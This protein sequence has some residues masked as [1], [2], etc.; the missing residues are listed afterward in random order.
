MSRPS[1]AGRYWPAHSF[2]HE[3]DAL[4]KLIVVFSL[5]FPV[6]LARDPTSILLPGLVVALLWVTALL[7]MH[8][9]L[10]TLRTFSWLIILTLIANLV[11]SPGAGQPA[12]PPQ[13]T[14]L[15][16]TAAAVNALRLV[17]LFVLGTWLTGTTSPLALTGAI[18]R[19]IAPLG[20][21]GLPTGD[22]VL[23]MSLGLRLLP[24]L[25]EA[26]GRVHLAQQARGVG[27]SRSWQ[28]RL[29]GAE[30]LVLA[31]FSLAF[32][33]ADELALAM[34]ARGYRP[35]QQAYRKRGRIGAPD[36]VALIGILLVTVALAW[37]GRRR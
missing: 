19:V 26:G 36:F 24:D 5:I 32:R 6:I 16:A 30:A 1:L 31:L 29:K 34:E 3:R 10:G 23:V 14:A 18:S 25:L 37:W 20:A 35:G 7:P 28:S 11:M 12:W 8:L 27:T 22:L 17:E 4:V 2:W 21:F 33:R 15:G 9:F 13:L